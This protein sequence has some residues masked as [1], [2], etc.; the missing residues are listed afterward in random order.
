MNPHEL[1]KFDDDFDLTPSIDR[2]VESYKSWL[3]V[4]SPSH[5]QGF[6][7][8]LREQPEA[9]RAE[10]VTFAILRQRGLRPRVGEVIGKGGVDFLCEPDRKPPVAVEV[11][12]ST[13]MRRWLRRGAPFRLQR[14]CSSRRP[15]SRRNDALLR[16]TGQGSDY[17][18]LVAALVTGG[19]FR[20]TS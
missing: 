5:L 8:R 17:M 1:V 16:S 9:A 14:R 15:R 3:E 4:K 10:A 19:L 11:T 12:S 13:C 7:G 18:T 20:V 2:V 6:A